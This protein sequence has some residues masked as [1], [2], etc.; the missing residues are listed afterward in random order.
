MTPPSSRRC[1]RHRAACLSQRN[2]AGMGTPAYM[3]PE[4]AAGRHDQLGPQSDVY[5]LGATLYHLLTGHAPYEE[6]DVGEVYQK[7]LAGDLPSEDVE[8]PDRAAAGGGLPQ[9]DGP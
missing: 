4:Q 7:V 8:S 2:R 1:G 9:S 6:T 5:C 3:S